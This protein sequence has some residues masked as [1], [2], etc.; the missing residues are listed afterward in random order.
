MNICIADMCLKLILK[1][2]NPMVRFDDKNDEMDDYLDNKYWRTGET[3]GANVVNIYPVAQLPP[4]GGQI[5][6]ETDICTVKL[7]G[8]AEVRIY[9]DGIIKRP[10]AIYSDSQE[11]GIHVWVD[12][13]WLKRYYQTN[14]VFNIC[15]VEKF[16][17]RNKK[18]IFHCCYVKKNEN[19]ILFSGDS[20]IGKSTQ[21]PR[22]SRKKEW[23]LACFWFS[24][25]RDIGNMPQCNQLFNGNYISAAG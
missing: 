2:Q 9:H 21:G 19:A 11:K 12:E 16:L 8:E 1:Q 20:G 5:V 7:S 6:W 17:I 18:A 4:V 13:N 14:Y 23:M 15:A 22:G 25:F 24:I 10:Y 3:P